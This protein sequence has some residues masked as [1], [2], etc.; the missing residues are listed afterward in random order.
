MK[1]VGWRL[2]AF[3]QGLFD[4]ARK[5]SISGQSALKGQPQFLRRLLALTRN[6]LSSGWA[7]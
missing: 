3:W 4:K 5:A 1:Q 2:P 7:M 6:A